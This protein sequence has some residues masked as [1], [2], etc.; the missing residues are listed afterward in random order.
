MS[1]SHSCRGIMLLLLSIAL[2][3]S[4]YA[5]TPAV[6]GAG[7]STTVENTASK[8]LLR[9]E[10]VNYAKELLGTRYRYAGRT[11]AGFDCSGLTLY[12]MRHFEVGLSSCSRAQINDGVKVNLNNVKEG[13]LIF[14]KRYRNRIS[15]VAMVVEKN[16]EGVFI[17][18][19]TSRGVVI[20]NLTKSKYWRPKVCGARDVLTNRDLPVA[21]LLAR[22]AA[23]IKA[24]QEEK[25]KKLAPQAFYMLYAAR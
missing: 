3:S 11:P 15:H 6:A 18:H 1:E 19:S 25:L 4:I 21:D 2:T 20:D 12:V 23:E 9:A 5:N 10:I 22:R 8:A 14:F 17:I 13:D 24:A 7:D 16:E